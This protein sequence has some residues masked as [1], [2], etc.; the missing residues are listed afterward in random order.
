[1][2]HTYIYGGMPKGP[3][4]AEAM[5]NSEKIMLVML[6]IIKLLYQSG[7]QLVENSVKYFLKFRNNFLKEHVLGW[8]E[9]LFGLSFI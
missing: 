7:S 6:A 5:S 9:S 1:M 3:S 4:Q 8:F 2:H